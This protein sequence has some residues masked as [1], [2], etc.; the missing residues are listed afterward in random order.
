MQTSKSDSSDVIAQIKSGHLKTSSTE[1]NKSKFGIQ[2]Q[3]IYFN[4]NEYL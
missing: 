4:D 3:V 1:E 2:T